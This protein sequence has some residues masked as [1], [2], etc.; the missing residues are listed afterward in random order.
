MHVRT[1]TCTCT[2]SILVH[3]HVHVHVCACNFYMQSHVL[4]TQQLYI[5]QD[6][7]SSIELAAYN[8]DV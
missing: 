1:Y 7:A 2:H 4:Y 5:V 8:M 3:V 6:Q